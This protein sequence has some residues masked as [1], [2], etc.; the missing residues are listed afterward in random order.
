[1]NNYHLIL[2][3]RLNIFLFF[4]K[5]TSYRIDIVGSDLWKILLYFSLKY[6]GQFDL[7]Y[8]ALERKERVGESL[9][10]KELF[11]TIKCSYTTISDDYPQHL[12]FINCP[13]FVLY[14]YGSLSLL[15]NEC[16]DYV[17][18]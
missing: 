2:K 1:M 4:E 15:D 16:I 5:E 12:K 7:I 11:A 9:K 8:K 6:H 17:N 3:K 10:K 18:W 13:P 14:Y